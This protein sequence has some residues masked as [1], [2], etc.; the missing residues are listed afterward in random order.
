MRKYFFVGV[1]VAF[2]LT[3][4]IPTWSEERSSGDIDSRLSTSQGKWDVPVRLAAASE[5]ATTP[6]QKTSTNLA[7]TWRGTYSY[8]FTDAAPVE[9]TVTIKADGDWLSGRISEPNTFGDK[10]SDKLFADIKGAVFEDGRIVLVKK[11]DGTG[12]VSHF[13]QYEGYLDQRQGTIR[14]KWLI[15]PNWWGTFRMVKAKE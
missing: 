6:R 12:G 14:G 7:G 11:Y 9:F 13:V 3:L 4:A 5:P 15:R 10:T 8:V 1:G 2:L